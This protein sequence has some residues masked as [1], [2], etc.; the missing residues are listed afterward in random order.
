MATSPTE[1]GIRRFAHLANLALLRLAIEEAKTSVLE[2]SDSPRAEQLSTAGI[3]ER[4]A[5]GQV[6]RN[7]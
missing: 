3:T 4:Q 2:D 5:D 6:P 1:A 7:R